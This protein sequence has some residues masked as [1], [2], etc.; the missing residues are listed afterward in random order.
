MTLKS[1][2][3]SNIYFRLRFGLANA[4]ITYL[5]LRIRVVCVCVCVGGFKTF[6]LKW[7]LIEFVIQNLSLIYGYIS[8]IFK[9]SVTTSF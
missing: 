7:V 4:I 3:N 5:R 8:E 1:Y 6:K 2:T 9:T